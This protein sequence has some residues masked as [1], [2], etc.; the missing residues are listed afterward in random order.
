[1]KWKDKI[2]SPGFITS[3][4]LVSI[5]L[6]QYWLLYFYSSYLGFHPTFL[7]STIEISII[8]L[9]NIVGYSATQVYR[10]RVEKR[11][12]EIILRQERDRI[13][14]IA[15]ITALGDLKNHLFR[16]NQTEKICE[17]LN[18]FIQEYFQVEHSSVYLW[19]DEEGAFYPHPVRKDS[20]RFFVYDPFM[21]WLT[22]NDQVLSRD[23]FEKA[24]AYSTIKEDAIRILDSVN[25]DIVIPLTLNASLLGI[26]FLGKRQDGS[27]MT[28]EDLDRLYEIKSTSVMSLS[29]AIFYARSTALTENL[30][31]KVKERTKALEE[32]Q[33][34]LVMSEKMA[35]LG[36][37]VAGIAH[38]INTPAGVING[39]ADN[40]EANLHYLIRQ[41]PEVIQYFND[42]VFTQKYINVI[43]QILIDNSRETLDPKDRF[44]KKREIRERILGQG[45]SSMLADDFATFLVEKNFLQQE[46]LILDLV[47]VGGAKIL[48]LIKHTTGINRNLKNI[49]YAIKNIVRIVRALK[50]YSHLDQAAYAEADLIEGI[51]NTLIIVHNQLKMGIQIERNFQPIPLVPCNLDELNQVWTNIIQNAI[52]AM[53]GKGILK[54]S[55]Y[56]E[57]PFVTVEIQDNGT[58]IKP[59]ILDRIWD[60]FFTT[61]DQGE[62]SGLGLGIVKGIIEKHKGKISATSKPG[63]TIFKIQLPYTNSQK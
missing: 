42:E 50:Y 61:K 30:E 12:Y 29:N 19:S 60:P 53:K 8:F 7:Q 6:I 24:P 57:E 32:A 2:K 35:S 62:G 25:S 5:T 49:K 31:N 34:Q 20:K 43:E 54:I 41:Y 22:D 37:M 38:E 13:N 58:G 47:K 46:E 28:S 11:R 56:L 26:L 59:E 4:T 44:K 21:L 40:M 23:H 15:Y 33:A 10:L 14:E 52:H 51:E 63:E 48:E 1:M 55:S 9:L 39:A 3:I 16:L 45:L 27:T 36:V 18:E 17:T